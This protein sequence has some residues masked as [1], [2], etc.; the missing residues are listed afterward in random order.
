MLPGAGSRHR[1]VGRVYDHDA[2]EIEELGWEEFIARQW[3]SIFVGYRSWSGM[4]TTARR[5]SDLL[6][7]GLG[8]SQEIADQLV[9]A[10]IIGGPER[11]LEGADARAVVSG[12]VAV[13]ADVRM[14]LAESALDPQAAAK[15]LDQHAKLLSFLRSY[16]LGDDDGGT[17]GT[18]GQPGERQDEDR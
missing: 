1:T 16:A 14:D 3:D 5:W 18:S 11:G 7:A 8:C 15:L 4:R 12:M 2:Q 10:E 17:S 6:E 13:L 9:Q